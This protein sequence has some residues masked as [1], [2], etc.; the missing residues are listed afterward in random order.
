MENKEKKPRSFYT[1]SGKLVEYGKSA[2]QNERLVSALLK[3]KEGNEI[4]LHTKAPGSPFCV[5]KGK[6]NAKDLEEAAVVCASFSQQWKKGKKKA[7]VHIFTSDQIIK[8]KGQAIGSFIVIGKVQKASVK[9]E[10]WLGVQKGKLY[11]AAKTCFEKP[12]IKLAPGKLSKEKAT[13]KIKEKL[14]KLDLKFSEQDITSAI[15]A[16]GFTLEC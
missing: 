6:P 13:E 12:L 4:I 5:I 16:G 2:E 8:E 14:E 11:A 7:E 3:E 15:P 10:L 9:I 1:S